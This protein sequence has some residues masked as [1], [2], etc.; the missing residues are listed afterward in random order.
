MKPHLLALLLTA[1]SAS[2]FAQSP[3][4]CKLEDQLNELFY[5]AK[6]S[7]GERDFILRNALAPTEGSCLSEGDEVSTA[8]LQYLLTHFAPYH[9]DAQLLALNDST[10]IQAAFIASLEA[11]S[12]FMALI[13][14]IDTRR[15]A[16]ADA[17]DTVDMNEMLD[18]AVKYFSILGL[19][20]EGHYRGKICAGINGI[21][22]TEAERHPHL[23]AFC[24]SSILENMGDETHSMYPVFVNGIRRLYTLQLGL[25]EEDR[26]LR[27]QGAMY[28]YMQGQPELRALLRMEYEKKKA[29]LPFLLKEEEGE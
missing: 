18:Y 23:E 17:Q 16:G 25:D 14:E 27:A 13:R 28:M 7:Y 21:T 4:G 6:K 19:T 10:A 26:L 11:D 9:K 3:E 8:Y 2:L 24:F 5:A 22:E 12:L 29:Y 1:L 20:P 15:T